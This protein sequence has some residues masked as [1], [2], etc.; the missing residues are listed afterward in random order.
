[1]HDRLKFAR[2][3]SVTEEPVDEE[4]WHVELDRWFGMGGFPAVDR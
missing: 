4:R 2:A 3:E 1:M